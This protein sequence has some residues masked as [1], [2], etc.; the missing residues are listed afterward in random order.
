MPSPSIRA[1]RAFGVP[2]LLAFV[3][4]VST[5]AGARPWP[6]P[7]PPRLLDAASFDRLLNDVRAEPFPDGKLERI[8]A[9]AGGKMFVFTGGQVVALLDTFTFWRD[10]LDALRLLPLVDAS[11]AEIVRRYF[12]AAPP[13]YSSEAARVLGLSP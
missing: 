7:R 5:S 3:F 10:R 1:M 13:L 9:V 6:R 8:R 2:T 12:E 4:C 11:N